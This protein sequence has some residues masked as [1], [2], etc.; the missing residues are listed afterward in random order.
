MHDKIFTKKGYGI[1]SCYNSLPL[2]G[3][4]STLMMNL[5]AIAERSESL[6]DLVTRTLPH[7]C[8]QQI[9]II[10]ARIPP[11]T[12]TL[13]RDELPGERS[14][15][16]NPDVF[17]PMF[18]MYGVAEAVSSRARKKGLPHVTVKKLQK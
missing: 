8:Q 14:L 7:Y 11:S 17:V 12:I 5:K 9:A 3:G 10:H 6:D 18:G 13:L 4:G 1:V 16:T 2:A 15:P